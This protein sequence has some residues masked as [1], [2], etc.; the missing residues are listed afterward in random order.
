[1]NRM[2]LNKEQIEKAK[3][4][5]I[6]IANQ[7][8][9]NCDNCEIALPPNTKTPNGLDLIETAEHLYTEFDKVKEKQDKLKEW[10][11]M[12]YTKERNSDW[13][14]YYCNNNEP[15]DRCKNCHWCEQGYEAL[16]EVDE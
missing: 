6:C 16:G 11:P 10:K 7:I 8:A 15:L 3:R 13:C 2:I 14:T 12:C 1:M 9:S 5:W 4:C